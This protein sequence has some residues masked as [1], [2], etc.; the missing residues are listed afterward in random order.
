[1]TPDLVGAAEELSAERLDQPDISALL[2]I[3]RASTTI[4]ANA[5][6]VLRNVG[7]ELS[8]REWDVLVGVSAVGP[9]R[10]S[11]ILRRASMTTSPQTLASLLDRLERK[12]MVA[13]TS[14]P[15]D[16]RGVLVSTTDK[17]TE[18]ALSLFPILARRVISTLNAHF[19]SEE[20]ET[21]SRLLQRLR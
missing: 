7:S 1:M 19:T 9:I 2:S 4:V 14:H 5:E 15:E 3:L 8:V 20:L 18:A 6:A 13:R 10:P 12:G 17:G 16:V 21:I 11:E